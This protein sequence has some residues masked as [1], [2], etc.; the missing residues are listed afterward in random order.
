[1]ALAKQDDIKELNNEKERLKKMKTNEEKKEHNPEKDSI[2]NK[3]VHKKT[4]GEPDKDNDDTPL[5]TENM[6]IPDEDDTS[7][8]RPPIDLQGSNSLF[9]N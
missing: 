1:M 3:K 4:T 2:N 7:P 8:F 9:N 6:D 5:K